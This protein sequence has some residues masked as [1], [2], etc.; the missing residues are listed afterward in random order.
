[1][2]VTFADPSTDVLT[3]QGLAGNDIIDTSG[4]AAVSIQFVWQP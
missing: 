1:V 2:H 3:V 4:L